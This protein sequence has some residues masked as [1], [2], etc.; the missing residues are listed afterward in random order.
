MRDLAPGLECGCAAVSGGVGHVNVGGG[1]G[2]RR[3]DRPKDGAAGAAVPARAGA[4]GCCAVPVVV[5]LAE[6]I[7]GL[8][9]N[10]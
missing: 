7:S 1:G 6:S 2:N 3:S 9:G 4:R 10:L 8:A 5:L